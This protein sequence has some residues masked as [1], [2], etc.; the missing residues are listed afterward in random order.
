MPDLLTVTPIIYARQYD[1]TN[2]AEMLVPITPEAGP[3]IVS[4]EDGVLTL[5]PGPIPFGSVTVQTGQYVIYECPDGYP[6]GQ[7]IPWLAVDTLDAYH[8][9][10]TNGGAA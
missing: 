2:S 6:P 5:A 9:L 1:G 3:A 4:E 10:A 8:V 7:R